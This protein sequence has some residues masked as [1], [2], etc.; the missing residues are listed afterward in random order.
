[1]PNSLRTLL[2]ALAL[3]LCMPSAPATAGK[4]SKSLKG[5]RFKLEGGDRSFV[6]PR[7]W[8]ARETDDGVEVS[9]PRFPDSAFALG[10]TNLDAKEQTMQIDA[11]ARQ[12]TRE[13][14]GGIPM[15]NLR[16]A[17]A[18]TLRGKP[19]ANLIM[20]GPVNGVPYRARVGTIRLGTQVAIFIAL[21]PVAYA[22]SIGPVF[23][24]VMQSFLGSPA[25]ANASQ[26]RQ[27]PATEPKAN[28]PKA[29]V[30]PRTNVALT[31]K[32]AGCWRSRSSTGGST[33]SSNTTKQL[34]FDSQGNYTYSY[35]SFVSTPYG[36]S[37]DSDDDDGRF[38]ITGATLNFSSNDT[39]KEDTETSVRIA[40]GF[41]HVGGTR[42]IPCT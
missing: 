17:V 34:R 18:T 36:S 6:V 42:Y 39:S 30:K 26:Q 2:V 14:L 33:G 22:P 7:G 16:A 40:N 25:S 19:Q 31:R 4:Q 28:E 1:M 24:T 38:F 11:L 35:R 27:A 9:H 21:Y 5:K 3:I 32:I 12:A 13:A 20:Q 41:L 8:S 23:D 15:K 29:N 10:I 37:R